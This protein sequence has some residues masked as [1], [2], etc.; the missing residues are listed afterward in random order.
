MVCFR[1]CTYVYITF[2]IIINF[3]H[4][5]TEMFA[6]R[7]SVFVENSFYFF[8]L[9]KKWVDNFLRISDC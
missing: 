3:V 5:Q 6:V 8:F 4:L 2:C 9:K 7:C 1:L